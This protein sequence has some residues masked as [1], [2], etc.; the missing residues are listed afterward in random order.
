MYEI[1]V[2]KDPILRKGGVGG[3]SAGGKDFN[4]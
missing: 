3:V 2:F 1:A 4:M